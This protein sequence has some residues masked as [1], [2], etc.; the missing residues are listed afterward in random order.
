MDAI[1]GSDNSDNTLG[2]LLKRFEARPHSQVAKR[3]FFRHSQRFFNN[4]DSL[5]LENI[6]KSCFPFKNCVIKFCNKFWAL[7]LPIVNNRSNH[8]SWFNPLVKTNP[9]VHFK[10]CWVVSSRARHLIK[11]VLIR[12][13]FNQSDWET[14]LSQSKRQTKAHGACAYNNNAIRVLHRNYL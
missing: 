6:R 4:F 11:E 13:R 9:I 8:A 2:L 10:G 14:S 3:V 12:T 7:P 1:R 5:A